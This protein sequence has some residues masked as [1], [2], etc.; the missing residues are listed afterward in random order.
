MKNTKTILNS[1]KCCAYS[2]LIVLWSDHNTAKVQQQTPFRLGKSRSKSC[3]M[4]NAVQIILL[5]HVLWP[6]IRIE[7]LA[8]RDRRSVLSVRRITWKNTSVVQHTKSNALFVYNYLFKSSQYLS[9][10]SK[11]SKYGFCETYNR[12]SKMQIIFGLLLA[13]TSASG[14]LKSLSKLL[15]RTTICS[16]G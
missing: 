10:S 8:F 11:F 3:P 12:I 6:N 1:N 7:E 15:L 9:I 13:L 16:V 5:V 14:R 4:H 2:F